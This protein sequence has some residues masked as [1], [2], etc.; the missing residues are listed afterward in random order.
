MHAT[1][2]EYTKSKTTKTAKAA[3]TTGLTGNI[4]NDNNGS[5]RPGPIDDN[6]VPKPDKWMYHWD[7]FFG[8]TSGY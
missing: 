1:F 7:C 5:P 8:Y 6:G 4:N 2:P 3:K